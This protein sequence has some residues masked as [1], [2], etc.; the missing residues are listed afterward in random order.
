MSYTLSQFG[1][2]AHS[3]KPR[4][5]FV[6]HI[7]TSKI[8]KRF[9]GAFPWVLVHNTFPSRAF[10]PVSLGFNVVFWVSMLFFWG[11][12]PRVKTLPEAQLTQGI[13]SVT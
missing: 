10:K 8:L 12:Q 7:L 1:Y 13:E 6:I 4:F 5:V 2:T 3:K 11:P 9:E